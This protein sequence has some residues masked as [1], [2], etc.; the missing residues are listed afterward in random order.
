MGDARIHFA[1]NRMVRGSGPLPREPFEAS[2]LDSQLD[3]AARRFLSN[4]RYVRLERGRRVVGL[5]E[6]L[7]WYE[8]DFLASAPSLIAYANRFRE[9]PIPSDWTVEFFGYD[10]TVNSQ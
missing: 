2:G 9:A 10:W 6:V 5:S 7:H 3:A 4:P 8:A 1:L